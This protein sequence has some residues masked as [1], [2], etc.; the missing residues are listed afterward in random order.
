MGRAYDSFWTASNNLMGVSTTI[1]LSRRSHRDPPG[2]AP[3]RAPLE[4]TEGVL[5]R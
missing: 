4:L 5:L 3:L 2:T 1:E